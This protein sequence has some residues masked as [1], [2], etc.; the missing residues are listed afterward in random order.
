[1]SGDWAGFY[2]LIAPAKRDAAI[3]SLIYFAAFAG[4][5]SET[6]SA[7][8]KRLMQSHGLDPEPPALDVSAAPGAQLSQWLASAKDRRKLFADLMALTRD[9]RK[10]DDKILNAS[11][12]LSDVRVTGDAATGT[13]TTPD[14][15]KKTMAFARVEGRWYLDE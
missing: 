5:G 6:A 13:L 14:G 12:V 11:A 15:K 10:T 7:E 1:M 9:R 8:Y 2:D 4:L 3:G